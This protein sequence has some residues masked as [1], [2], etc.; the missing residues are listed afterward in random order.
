MLFFLDTQVGKFSIQTSGLAMRS[1]STSDIVVL[2]YKPVVMLTFAQEFSRE[3]L[4]HF[5]AEFFQLLFTSN[6]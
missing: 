1:T 5:L 2:E 6:K 4:R 3:L